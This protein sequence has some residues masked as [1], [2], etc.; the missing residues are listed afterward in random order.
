MLTLTDSGDGSRSRVPGLPGM[1]DLEDFLAP[2]FS[3]TQP[4]PLWAFIGNEHV[5]GSCLSLS[6]SQIKFRETNFLKN[7]YLGRAAAH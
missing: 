4:Q 7:I 1:R 5:K 3:L 6:A 2:S